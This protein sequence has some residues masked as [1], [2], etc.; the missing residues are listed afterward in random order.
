MTKPK[1]GRARRKTEPKVDGPAWGV[2][3]IGGAAL[4]A[5]G[6]CSGLEQPVPVAELGARQD[7]TRDLP[8]P[9][10]VAAAWRARIGSALLA[11]LTA[12][13]PVL[14]GAAGDGTVA[15]LST[16]TGEVFWT[17]EVPGAVGGGVI[18]DGL[19][20][21]VASADEHGG[22]YAL[23][24]RDG[25][26]LWE[27]RVGAVSFAPAVARDTV[28]L[29][30]DDGTVYALDAGTGREAWRTRLTGRAAASPVVDATAVVAATTADTLYW[31]ARGTGEVVA[32]HALAAGVSAEPR[33]AGE[34]LYLPLHSGA[35]AAYDLA[36]RRPL[37]RAETGEPILA[38][39]VV[40]RDG[41]VYVLNRAAGV[42]RIAP[43][44]AATPMAELGG[45]ARGSLTLA[46]ERLLV[47][48]LDGTLLALDTTGATVWSE[49]LD[50]SIVAPVAVAGGAI[51]VPLLRGTVV[52]L[53][54][55]Q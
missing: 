25:V 16:A 18:R 37:W 47:G 3:F 35:V 34:R 38:A 54:G 6:A 31:L 20:L 48:L 33:R 22:V 44:G 12:E 15:A 41:T 49:R 55:V 26:R 50:D 14:L 2:N 8:V 27:R 10:S 24:L 23:R 9:D 13:D 21:F 19:R 39:P 11:S 51:Y 29:A 52:K 28:Y 42:W 36:G 7:A 30:A 45:A 40:A 17:R 43:D 32:R 53:E 46:G 1:R 4:V 5:L